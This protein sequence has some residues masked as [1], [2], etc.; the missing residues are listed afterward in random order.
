TGADE[1]GRDLNHRRDD[2]RVLRDRQPRHRDHAQ[3]HRDDRDD[4]RDE[5]TVDEKAGHDYFPSFAG[6]A[7]AAVAGGAFG[8]TVIPSWIRCRPSTTTRSPGLSPSSMTHIDSTRG[9]TFTLRNDTLPLSSTTAT[10]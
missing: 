8:E 7:C 9:P 3:Q 2:L 4:H 5:R 6:C 1:G 10:L